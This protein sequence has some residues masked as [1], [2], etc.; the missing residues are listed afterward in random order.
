MHRGHHRGSSVWTRWLHPATLPR[1][2]A[3]SRM[4]PGSA[5]CLAREMNAAENSHARRTPPGFLRL[6]AVAPSRDS[7]KS[8][9]AQSDAAGACAALG[10]GDGFTVRVSPPGE[11]CGTAEE[12]GGSTWGAPT[13]AATIVTKAPSPMPTSHPHSL[14]CSLRDASTLP[15]SD[16]WLESVFLSSFPGG[17]PLCLRAASTPDSLD[18][19]MIPSPLI[20]SASPWRRS[21]PVKSPHNQNLTMAETTTGTFPPRRPPRGDGGGRRSLPTFQTRHAASTPQGF[22]VQGDAVWLTFSASADD[23]GRRSRAF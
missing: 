2:F 15:A 8:L 5:L 6:D 23:K 7:P 16:A 17:S 13:T 18:A 9:G 3:L 11:C 14:R 12:G 21:G 20:P 19:P 1:A 10:A 22:S 4:Q